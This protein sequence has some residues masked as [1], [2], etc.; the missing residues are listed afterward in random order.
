[1]TKISIIGGGKI[2]EALISGLVSSGVN[3][4]DI[5][6]AN[7]RPERGKE[8]F[9]AYGIVDYTDVTQAVDDVDTVFLCV[10]PKDIVSVLAEMSETLDNNAQDTTVISMAAGITLRAMEEVVSAGTPVVRVMPNTPMLVR[11]GTLAV[12]VGRFVGAEE[13]ADIEELLRA[14]GD[15][16]VVEESQMD[17]VVA[18]SG[19]SPAYYFLFVEAMI[20]AGISLG[21]PRDLARDLAVSSAHGAALLMKETGEEP[22]LLRANVSSPGGTTIAAIRELEESGLRG[23]I[24]RATS[25]CAERNAQLGA[26]RPAPKHSVLSPTANG[27]T[28]DD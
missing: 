22:S 25:K 8:L 2:G 28:E 27:E 17:A 5:H 16:F 26:P 6:V 3:P 1:M 10:K 24:Y 15:V 18:M 21:L 20:D 14:V 23:A 7:R 4:K 11:S 13:L 9:D 12:S 19:S